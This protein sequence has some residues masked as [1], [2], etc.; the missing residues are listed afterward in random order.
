MT[1]ILHGHARKPNNNRIIIY[2][3]QHRHRRDT[4]S[5]NPSQLYTYIHQA[6]ISQQKQG[7]MHAL[8][9]W[10]IQFSLKASS[11]LYLAKT[12]TAKRPTCHHRALCIVLVLQYILRSI[13][14][15]LIVYLV[16]VDWSRMSASNWNVA[17]SIVCVVFCAG[18]SAGLIRQIG[19]DRCRKSLRFG[20]LLVHRCAR[21]LADVSRLLNGLYVL[22]MLARVIASIACACGF[23]TLRSPRV[24]SAQSHR[25]RRCPA[26]SV[27]LNI[28]K[29][30]HH[31][32]PHRLEKQMHYN[33]NAPMQ[34]KS[35]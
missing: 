9:W 5:T 33:I 10:Q 4:T 2:V 7:V 13:R 6:Y 29:T 23:I 18:V 11:S 17:A 21:T 26:G 35:A 28:A 27:Q 31:T 16:A 14:C 24:R 19:A 1:H 32:T 8:K 22:Y 12:Y 34:C 20:R 3:P 30:P 15:V 25:N